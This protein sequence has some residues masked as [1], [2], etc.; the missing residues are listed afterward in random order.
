[1]KYQLNSEGDP[2]TL[3]AT[4]TS[5]LSPRLRFLRSRKDWL[6]PSSWENACKDHYLII[7]DKSLDTMAVDSQTRNMLGLKS[8]QEPL[9]QLCHFNKIKSEGSHSMRSIIKVYSAS[10]SLTH[11]IS[12]VKSNM[13]LQMDAHY[14]CV[15]KPRTTGTALLVT[16]ALGKIL[17]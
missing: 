14:D 11:S 17:N 13:I 2:S 3:A 4:D 6:L 12:F 8:R 15:C 16:D 1:M 7:S 9:N 5:T 10:R